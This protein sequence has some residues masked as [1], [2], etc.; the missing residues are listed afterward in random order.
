MRRGPPKIGRRRRSPS[1]QHREPLMYPPLHLR[2]LTDKEAKAIAKLA[3]SQTAPWRLVSLAPASSGWPAKASLF[4][5]SALSSS[6]PPTSCAGGSNDLTRRAWR[7]WRMPP[8]RNAP[9]LH[10]RRPRGSWRSR[11]RRP[12]T[13]TYPT[14]AGLSRG[15]PPTSANR[16]ASPCSRRAFISS[17]RRQASAYSLRRCV[18]ARRLP[19]LP[20]CGVG[21]S[22]WYRTPRRVEHRCMGCGNHHLESP[23]V[24]EYLP[25]LDRDGTQRIQHPDWP[26]TGWLARWQC[27]LCEH[28]HFVAVTAGQVACWGYDL[29]GWI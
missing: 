26:T 24:L 6:W 27:P 10:G 21:P 12:R 28:E 2:P 17:C 1:L 13:W 7:V 18:M 3:R 16:K 8:L 11:V 14:V 15:W 19:D 20:P 23:H 4:R 25:D 5:R 9:A 22:D 29:G